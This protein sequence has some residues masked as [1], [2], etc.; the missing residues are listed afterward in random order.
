MMIY[1]RFEISEVLKATVKSRNFVKAENYKKSF[2]RTREMGPNSARRDPF[3][4]KFCQAQQTNEKVWKS[5]K[6]YN[7][8]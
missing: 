2:S 1:L 6:K 7:Y 5:I 3:K 4:S 8:M